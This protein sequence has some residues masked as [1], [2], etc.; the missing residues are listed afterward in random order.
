VSLREAVAADQA[1]AGQLGPTRLAPLSEAVAAQG[2]ALQRADS[3]LAS[4]GAA[5]AE[6]E[7]RL[8]SLR[9]AVADGQALPR[10][11]DEPRCHATE[12]EAAAPQAPAQLD[13][14]N[15]DKEV[16]VAGLAE[17]AG[18]YDEMIAHMEAVCKLPDELTELER[19][20]LSMAYKGAAGDRLAAWRSITSAERGARIEGTWEEVK[21]AREYRERVEA[22]LTKICGS[23]LGLLDGGLIARAS[24]DEARVFYQGMKAQYLGYIAEV[25]AGVAKK[26]AA[27]RTRLAYEAASRVAAGGLAA[28]HLGRLGLAFNYSVFSYNVL[29][30]SDEACRLARTAYEDAVAALDGAPQDP[31][32]DVMLQRLWDNLTCWMRR[33]ARGGACC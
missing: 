31:G 27:G 26:K 29:G 2:L 5:L 7:L 23:I 33:G 18:R 17:L 10:R 13:S 9:E 22:E 14:T 1:G 32:R 4:L 24:T 11:P 6:H 20:L 16:F 3:C 25:S 15:R 28:T 12:S 8:A 21:H 19:D 30:D